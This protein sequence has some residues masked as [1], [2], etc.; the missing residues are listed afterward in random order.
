M[1]SIDGS[2]ALV[3]GGSSNGFG[4]PWTPA[5]ELVSTP[6]SRGALTAVTGSIAGIA[7]SLAQAGRAPVPRVRPTPISRDDG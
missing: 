6:A 2:V 4:R 5:S 1:T 3:T 7:L